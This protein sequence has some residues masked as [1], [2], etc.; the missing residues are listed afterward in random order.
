MDDTDTTKQQELD[1]KERGRSTSVS[2]PSPHICFSWKPATLLVR[3]LQCRHL[4]SER[5]LEPLITVKAGG[6]TEKTCQY[7]ECVALGM[8]AKSRLPSSCTTVVTITLA[9]RGTVADEM[10]G[11]A[12]VR[13]A[14]QPF[15][16]EHIIIPH[17][18]SPRCISIS[19]FT[20]VFITMEGT[21]VTQVTATAT[22]TAIAHV[23][24]YHSFTRS[25]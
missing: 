17:M 22:A 11:T 10:I 1:N 25:L 6:V 12:E 23:L 7:G 4:T 8:K 16:F 19:L 2:C 24:M 13:P 21:C 5:R 14:N 18:S 9:H 20:F 3:V 15:C